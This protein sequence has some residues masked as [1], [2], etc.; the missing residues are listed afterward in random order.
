MQNR[1]AAALPT[2]DNIIKFYRLLKLV[3]PKSLDSLT[4]NVERYGGITIAHINA[5]GMFSKKVHNGK[6]IPI[7]SKKI[8][9]IVFGDLQ[10]FIVLD[11]HLLKNTNRV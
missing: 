10:L 8:F 11:V 6:C 9:D 1:D 3:T 5:W 2:C 4:S 7:R